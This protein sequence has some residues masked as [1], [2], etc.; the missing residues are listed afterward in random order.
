M[1][2][3]SPVSCLTSRRQDQVLPVPR[4]TRVPLNDDIA[5][6]TANIRSRNSGILHLQEP[7][8]NGR[9][10]N[11]VEDSMDWEWIGRLVIASRVLRWERVVWGW[12]VNLL[13]LTSSEQHLIHIRSAYKSIWPISDVYFM[14]LEHGKNILIRGHSSLKT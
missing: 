1:L 9:L 2:S 12:Y 5:M 10:I 7:G 14:L 8:V 11:V 13:I 6:V 3:I 4:S